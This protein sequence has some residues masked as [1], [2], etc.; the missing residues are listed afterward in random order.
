MSTS[1]IAV[2]QF[3]GKRGSQ[4]TTT[5]DRKPM[6]TP[7]VPGKCPNTPGGAHNPRWEER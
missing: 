3:C 5:N 6:A 2:C 1:W 7:H 4:Q